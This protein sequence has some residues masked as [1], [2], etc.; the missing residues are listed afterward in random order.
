MD[1]LQRKHPHCHTIYSR[2]IPCDHE[3]LT[4]LS[5]APEKARSRQFYDCATENALK[6]LYRTY[7]QRIQYTLNHPLI[8]TSVYAGIQ[9][10]VTLSAKN[11]QR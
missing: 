1:F 8:G 7:S 2:I 3:S 11:A 10:V 9:G 5:G 6:T 4:A